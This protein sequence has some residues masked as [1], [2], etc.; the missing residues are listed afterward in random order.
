MDLK[1]PLKVPMEFGMTRRLVATVVMVSF[2]VLVLAI[3]FRAFERE[4]SLKLQSENLKSNT[5]IR[6]SASCGAAVWQFDEQ[7]LNTILRSELLDPSLV[8]IRIFQNENDTIEWL[9]RDP[10]QAVVR[11]TG[12]PVGDYE[13]RSFP[14]RYG[15]DNEPLATLATVTLWFDDTPL[16]TAMLSDILWNVILVSFIVLTLTLSLSWSV[17]RRLVRPLETIRSGLIEAAAQSSQGSDSIAIL[18][19][20]PRSAFPELERMAKDLDGVFGKISGA[21]SKQ[22]STEAKIQNLND[23]LESLVVERT[24]ELAKTNQE[25]NQAMDSLRKVQ[26]ELVN[27][28][29]LAVLGRLVAS[30]AHEI[31]TPLG[32]IVSSNSTMAI[33]LEG[34]DREILPPYNSLSEQGRALFGILLK[35][36]KERVFPN[37][38]PD[39]RQ[40]R[41]RFAALL[42]AK[43][44]TD[45]ESMADTL[46]ECGFRSTDSELETLLTIPDHAQAIELAGQVAAILFASTIVQVASEKVTNFVAALK[47]YSRSSHHDETVSVDIPRSL[48]TVLVLFQHEIKLGIEIVRDFQPVPSARCLSGIQ[49]VWTNLISNAF[50]AMGHHGLLTIRVFEHD[51]SIVVEIEDNGIGIQPVVQSRVFSPFFTTKKPGEGTGLGLDIARRIVL[52]SGGSINFK[53][54]PGQTVFTVTLPSMELLP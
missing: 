39:D 3:G 28:A 25:L 1:P 47:T 14:I 43:G 41:K 50:H 20:L 33:G 30:I 5:A 12:P 15:R 32:A 40:T 42:A 9:T 31:N 51:G 10:R 37:D 11:V 44:V 52:E 22:K 21:I 17:L 46:V 6:I 4:S 7:A 27:S 23:N 26:D 24:A 45:P 38:Q 13:S 29:Q 54:Q 16:R 19:R 35:S 18:E 53:S 2:V 8:S 36:A 34:L 49:Q 48:E